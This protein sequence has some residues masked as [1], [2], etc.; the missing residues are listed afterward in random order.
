MTL[1]EYVSV[2]YHLG[3]RH[4]WTVLLTALS[5]AA[6]VM[7]AAGLVLLLPIFEFIQ[8]N[9]NVES[10]AATSRLW[11]GL[12]AAF[13]FL[14]LKIS[15]PI[16]MA[17][18]LS[19]ILA[20]QFFTFL[21]TVA[22]Q[23]VA[24]AIMRRLRVKGARAYLHASATYHDK[25]KLGEVINTLT[26]EASSAGAAL[27]AP[28]RIF[29]IIAIGAVY[30][31]TLGLLSPALTAYALILGALVGV[32]LLKIMQ[33]TQ[34]AGRSR[35]AATDQWF[36][37]LIRRLQ[38]ARLIRI[39]GMEDAEA[40]AINSQAAML[41]NRSVEI[42]RLR[43][44][45]DVLVEPIVAAFA[46]ALLYFAT[47]DYG[48]TIGEVGLFLVILMRLSPVARSAA[49]EAQQ[50]AAN[51]PALQAVGSRIREMEQAAEVE[52]GSELFT[53]FR[54]AIRLED[55]WF[56][57]PSREEFALKGIDLA[58]ERGHLVA[59]VGPSGAGKSTI[60]DLLFRIREPVA[61]RILVD[62]KPISEFTRKSV[63]QHIGYIPQS[64]QTLAET[65]GEHVAYGSADMPKAE[66][67]E[68][69]RMAGAE[70][71][72]SQLPLGSRTALQ[73]IGSGLSGGQLQRI[74]L[75]RALSRKSALLVMDEPTSNLDA[76]SEA[77]FRATLSDLL[78]TGEHTIVIVAHRL[79]LVSEADCIAVIEDGAILER[80]RHEELMTRNGWYASAWR[81]QN[82]AEDSFAGVPRALAGR[83]A[84]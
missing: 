66:V 7:E 49:S 69:L 41:E 18:S 14:G 54:N 28:A 13:D 71:F 80:G 27:T 9:G 35:L 56:R 24:E 25:V 81:Q 40:Q 48:M 19:L 57:Y 29:G 58:I 63:R 78:A 77:A 39:S 11:S 68:A 52:T 15:L 53:R 4:K 76:K 10:L 30:V 45:G 44:W 64:P 31:S 16:L 12:T 17:A 59:L 6:T 46:L 43:A 74:E 20:R 65:I 70:Q 62:G 23:L 33:A 83:I 47:Q 2:S 67:D 22:N 37:L 3:Y 32:T 42:T 26:T 34:R 8:S 51:L 79:S 36:K 60:V 1:R 72:V 55:V 5:L 21:K 84:D 75:A 61:G 73:E 82:S 38:N 50:L